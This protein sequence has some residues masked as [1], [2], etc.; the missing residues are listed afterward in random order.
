MCYQFDGLC[1]HCLLVVAMLTVFICVFKDQ[2]ASE[3][4]KLIKEFTEVK[5]MHA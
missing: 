5:F 3:A 4:N 2:I 1:L